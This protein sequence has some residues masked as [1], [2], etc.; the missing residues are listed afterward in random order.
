M[1]GEIDVVLESLCANASSNVEL[2][3]RAIHKII[4]GFKN[5]H[6]ALT[7]PNL[8]N[9][10][11]S[12]GISM[13]KSSIY[14]KQ[15]R[16]NDNPYRVL[17]DRWSEH[18]ANSKLKKIEPN[19]KVNFTI[20]SDADYASIGSDVVKFKVQNMYSELR[21]A[22]H[23]INLL[24]DIHSLPILEDSGA[25]LLFHKDEKSVLAK[26]L[27]ASHGLENIS[28]HIYTLE[29]FMSGGTKLTFDTEGFLVADAIIRKGDTL[30]EME[31]QQALAAAIHIMKNV[32]RDN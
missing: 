22:R 16:G 12:V 28:Q 18:I 20:M 2:R 25:E 26:S 11:S 1:A 9:A 4:K 30:S 24:K 13:S 6:V 5:N 3:L 15:I 23:Q 17:V 32:A 10:L 19:A 27:M 14:N 7:A 29:S 21:A 31:F 8:V